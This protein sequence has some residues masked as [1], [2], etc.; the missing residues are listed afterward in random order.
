M[1][2]A[3]RDVQRLEV[4]TAKSME[5]SHA[6]EASQKNFLAFY[7]SWRFITVFTGACHLSLSR[8]RLIHSILF[9]LKHNMPGKLN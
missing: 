9:L 6:S 5:Q 4:L 8:A 1:T 7:G 3:V 2:V